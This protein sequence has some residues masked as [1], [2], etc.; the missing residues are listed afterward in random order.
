MVFGPSTYDVPLLPYE[1]ELIKTIGITEE[2]YQLFA[3]EVR[4]RGA[5][6]PSEYNNIPD[7]VNSADPVTLF[8]INLAIGLV[9]TGVS[10]LLTPKPKMPSAQQRRGG[11]AVDLG[12]ITGANRFTP[13]R[14]FETLA[15][16][17]DY[18]SPIPLVFGLY[19]SVTKTGGMLITPK[20]VWSR[21]FSHGTLQRAKL[22][23]VVGEKGLVNADTNKPSGV[24]APDLEGIFLGNNALDHVF[25]DFFAFYW[26]SNDDTEKRI[27]TKDKQYGTVG[28]KG[29][30]SDSLT[31]DD[32]EVFVCPTVGTERE[33]AFCHAYSPANST[34]FGVFAPIANGNSYRLNYRIVSIAADSDKA[35]RYLQ[36]LTRIKIAGVGNEDYELDGNLSQDNIKAVRALNQD[37]EARNYSPRMG[38]IELTKKSNGSVEKAE[39]GNLKGTFD[40]SVGD[41]IRFLISASSIDKDFYKNRN[42]K[43]ES[44]D[45]INSAVAS[46]QLAADSAMQLGEKFS[47]AGSIWKVTDRSEVVFNPDGNDDQNIYLECID[48]SHSLTKRIGVVSRTRVVEPEKE[49][50]GDSSPDN[51]PGH[52]IGEGFFPITQTTSAVVTNNRPAVVTEIGI[53]STVFQRLNGLCAFNSLI[54]PGELSDYEEDNVQV[55][56]GTITS[57]IARASA[58]RIF[59]KKVGVDSNN[60]PFELKP[61]EELYFVVRGSRPVAQ[62]NSI[63]IY[64]FQAVELEFEF[65]PLA[66][67]ELR[68]LPDEQ[69]MTE[70]LFSGKHERRAYSVQ[71]LGTLEVSAASQ[72]I[73]KGNMKVNKEFLRDPKTT[74]GSSVKGAPNSVSRVQ[75]VPGPIS[76]TLP[77]SIARVSNISNLTTDAG[78]T[79]AFAYAL[80]GSASNDPLPVGGTKTIKTKEIIE[81]SPFRWIALNW[82]F[83]KVELPVDHYVRQ[84]GIGENHSWSPTQVDVIGSTGGF[85]LNQEIDVKRGAQ[86]SAAI[87]GVGTAYP[88]SNP[89]AY[90]PDT[91]QTMTWSGRRFK[92]TSVEN[93]DTVGGR[94]Q[95][96]YHEIFGAA[97]SYSVGASQTRQ[98]TTTNDGGAKV[99]N[100]A[101]TSTV[102][103]TSENFT[104][105][106]EFVWNSPTVSIVSAG[107]TS[108]WDQGEKFTHTLN[109]STNNPF[110]TS[111]S[112]AGAVYEIGA[113]DETIKEPTVSSEL[114]FADQSQYVDIS[115]YRELVDKSNADS[116]EHQIVYVN[117]ILENN[118]EPN[119]NSL[120]LAGLS[121][122]ASREFTQLDQ[123]RCWVG[124]GIHVERL[125]PDRTNVYGD[126][127]AIGPSNLLT[128]LVYYLMTDQTGGAG[129]LLGMTANNPSLVDKEAMKQTSKFLHGQ[130]LTFNGPIT[131]RTNLRQFMM[132]IAPNFLC[133]LVI[134]DGKFAL[135]PALP[136]NEDSGAI[137]QGPVPI[138]QLFT[139]GNILENTFKIEYL[140]SE[141]R[142]PFKA[143][144]RYRQERKNKFPEEQTIEIKGVGPKYNDSSPSDEDNNDD[145]N[146]ELIPLEQFDL[147]QFCTSEH[148]AVLVAKYFLALRR[149]VTHTVSFSTTVHGL[150][151]KAG[152][153]IKVITESSPYSSAN[154]GTVSSSGAV[155]SVSEL[156]D[157]QYN[158]TFFKAGSEDIDTGVMNVS[159][160]HV[161]DSAFQ[162]CVFTLTNDTVS[163][164]VYVVEQLTFSQ[165]GTVDIVASEHPCDD[166]GKSLLVNEIL[167]EP[168][169]IGGTVS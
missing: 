157:G 22:L 126:N 69:I 6:R 132:D 62:Y 57:V 144:V 52:G 101:L 153:Y 159:N 96:Y 38:I 1:R 37:S 74:K 151:L 128:D 123:L 2:E 100:F 142:R 131:D 140:R 93:T 35:A 97:S 83:T 71:G 41:T 148:H 109:I 135:K 75:I 136:T 10:Y 40:V 17:A 7:V 77:T 152:S 32:D 12:S 137:N 149:L 103:Q 4:R 120:T 49:F 24:L 160:G 145:N 118:A 33:T 29:G 61:I 115:A 111:Y 55:T 89:F 94:N 79:G 158:V 19:D 45:D 155:T 146:I 46:M 30:D 107:T 39:S 3:A 47:I 56:S 119:F 117:E 141:E 121:L 113:I 64:N 76:G 104:G 31:A 48:T 138:S 127:N 85:N 36:T 129:A 105:I 163:Q 13:S 147:T 80:L 59:V 122:K 15:E 164:N 26:K 92:I 58:F 116:P 124:A 133:N 78:K 102:R 72:L 90:N 167:N 150:N 14:G 168:F 53:K 95:G 106:E 9:L 23:F 110:R 112:K 63:R 66:G 11:G 143:V 60:N 34:E 108:G 43:G 84:K 16:L 86:S 42:N 65:V 8:F 88:S 82:T 54:T 20:L 166:D 91:G 156:A 169:N 68:G 139:N 114:S 27:R 99:L 5:I 130:R 98:F 134:F 87:N 165:E 51:G 125:H 25:E 81:A 73:T 44:V 161:Q 67:S 18:A 162:D 21:M 50:I 70:L 28:E 154:N